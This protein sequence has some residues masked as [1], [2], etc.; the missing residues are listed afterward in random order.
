MGSGQ[1]CQNTEQ[2]RKKKANVTPL[3]KKGKREEP[4]NYRPISLI[5]IPGEV[6]EQ[7]VETISRQMKD[8][9]I[10]RSSQHCFTMGK[11]RLI[12]LIAF[13]SE[14]TGLEKE[15]ATLNIGYLHFSKAFDSLP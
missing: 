6:T 3:F 11:S 8:M 9:E 2:R 12:N 4:R 13:Y 10:I 7:I 14:M 5:L 15:R 1:R